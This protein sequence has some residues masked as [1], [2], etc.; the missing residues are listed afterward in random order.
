MGFKNR[1][2]F[3]I[4]DSIS[5]HYGPYLK[6]MIKN[7]FNYDRKRGIKESLEDLD[8]PVVSN[9]GDSFM[10]LKY[11][12]EENKKNVKYDILLINC[13]MHDI[14]VEKDL[15]RKQIDECEYK[16]NVNRII[17]LSKHM[18]NKVIWV[19]TTPFNEKIHNSRQGG[20]LR[21][22]KDIEIYNSIAEEIMTNKNIEY[23]D[24][25]N[26]TKTLGE[27]IH[28]DHVHFIEEV[29]KLQYAFISGYLYNLKS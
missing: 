9:A 18:S 23:I 15:L 25:Y 19:T 17:D 1:S 10:V 5:I 4:G 14:R 16:I 21:Y 26:F 12:L 2:V 22:S 20:F 6:H 8:K 11:L 3:V 28:C 7:K 29:R 24:L 27:D 13:G